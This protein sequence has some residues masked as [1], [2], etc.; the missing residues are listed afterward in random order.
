[1]KIPANAQGLWQRDSIVF[2]SGIRDNTTQIF[3]AQTASLFVD[4]RIPKDRPSMVSPDLSLLSEA[5]LVRMCEQKGFAGRLH[6]NGS[7]FTWRRAVDFR[8]PNVRADEAILRIVGD[9]L[10]EEGDP[11]AILAEQYVETYTRRRTGAT[12][13]I[14]LELLSHTGKPFCRAGAQA[15]FLVIIDDVF[16]FAR[17]RP[18]IVLPHAETLAEL[19]LD[20]KR[21]GL[22][23]SPLLDCH[24]AKGTI[25]GAIPFEIS[26]STH[27]WTE[28]QPIF[29]AD[30]AKVLKDRLTIDHGDSASVWRIC[31]S[32]VS[33]DDLVKIFIS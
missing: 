2:E 18:R 13:S 8:P 19:V 33:P 25:T 12:S 28:G 24:I 5:G 4:I 7:L 15:A 31:E 30:S 32:N 17:P 16:M 1:M 10:Y 26:L 9:K 23:V 22:P 21:Q 11:T 6:Y 27:P 3:W 20:A 29:A 14:A